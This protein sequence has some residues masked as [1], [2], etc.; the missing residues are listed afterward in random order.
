MQETLKKATIYLYIGPMFAGK[1]ERMLRE[2][3]IY[4]HVSSAMVILFKYSGDDREKGGTV[5]SRSGAS[6]QADALIST[7]QEAW[8]YVK[9]AVERSPD[10]SIVVV[11]VD[12]GQFIDGLDWFVKKILT[13]K[14]RARVKFKV[15]IAALDS[16]FRAEM[17]ERVVKLIPYC[18]KVRKNSAK[19]SLCQILPAQL[20]KKIG[21]TGQLEEIGSEQYKAVCLDCY[22]M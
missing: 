4:T 22:N 1:T 10:K 16:T 8:S 20:T 21:G 2:L 12:E 6:G 9:E 18:H 19:C 15:H 13:T 11:G 14:L 7:G 17:W 3:R 5:L